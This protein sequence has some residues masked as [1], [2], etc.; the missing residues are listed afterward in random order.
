LNQGLLVEEVRRLLRMPSVSGTGEGIVETAGYLRDWLRE[1]VGARVQLLSYGGH[2]I[3]YGRLD[4]GAPRTVIVYNMYDVQP[5]EPLDEWESPPFEASI[6][7]DRIIARG[8]YNTKGALMSCLLGIEAF[9]KVGREPPVNLVFVLE[10]EEEL[11]SPSMPKFVEDKGGE[12]RGADLAYFAIPSERVRGKPTIVLGNKGIVFVEL[13]V[14]T[15]KYDVHSSFSRGLYNPA[16]ILARIASE[17]IDPLGGP[18]VQWLEDKTIMPTSEDLEYLNDIMEAS[19]REELLNLYGVR[20]ARL[21][22]VDWYIAV[23]FKPTVNIDGFTSGYTGPGTK[24]ITP[25]EATMRLD[26]RLVP[27]VEPEDVVRGLKELIER[28]GLSKHVELEVHDAYTWSK[29]NPK[30]P[31]VRRAVEAYEELN[32]KPYIIPILPGSAPSY[33]FTRKLGVPFIATAPGHGGRA[34]APNEYITV[35]TIPKITLYTATL[36]LKVGE[37]K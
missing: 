27:N 8:A 26:F 35:D 31:M 2:P 7:G 22:D 37:M 34:H 9:L 17:L 29:T 5:V 18:R 16:A 33:L 12:L 21:K 15:S 10:G 14:K 32:L 11:G 6:V 23:Y 1:R 24:T 3:V 13:K 20:E 4:V 19:P 36:L 25:A 28:L 30:H